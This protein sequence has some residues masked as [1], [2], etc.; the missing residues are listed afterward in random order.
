MAS[1]FTDLLRIEEMATGEKDN[2]WGAIT[3]ANLDKLEQAIA[4]TQALAFVSS[5]ITLTENDGGDGSSETAVNAIL[6]C[7]GILSGNVN[8]VAPKLSKLYI[9][10]NNTTASFTLKIKCSGTT[11][12]QELDIPQGDTL[13]VWC[14]PAADSGNGQFFSVKAPVS[15]TVAQATNADQLGGVVAANYAQLAVKNSWTKPQIVD[16]VQASLTTGGTPDTYT[17]NADTESTIIIAQSEITVDDVQIN[18][19]TGTPKDGQIMVF[20]VEQHASTPVSIVWGTEF[21]F[22]DDTNIDL[23]QTASKVDSFSFMYSLNLDRWLALGAAL[24]FPRS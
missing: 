9:V 15:G 24:N 8:I 20:I 19:P 14:D 4:G 16:A 5:D 17:P 10:V 7:T 21:V 22:P 18:N 23:T 11:G 12:G 1:T 3:N 6:L 13:L 2:T